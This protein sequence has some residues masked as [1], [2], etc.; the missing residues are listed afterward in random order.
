MI[1]AAD[2]VTID[3]IFFAAGAI[4]GLIGLGLPVVCMGLLTLIMTPAE[5]A[6]VVVV[7]AFIT[8]IQQA[9]VGPHLRAVFM[10]LWPMLLG[11]VVGTFAAGGLILVVDP[12]LALG[13]M[14]T[15]LL[16]YVMFAWSNVVL[17]VPR[18]LEPWAAPVVGFCTGGVAGTTGVLSIPSVPY[19]QALGLDK[20]ALVQALGLSFLVSTVAL[21]FSLASDITVDGAFLGQSAETI[22]VAVVGTW[23]GQHLRQFVSAHHFRTLFLAGLAGIGFSLCY[24]AAAD[25]PGHAFAS[26]LDGL[27]MIGH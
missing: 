13:L 18:P 11:I 1:F 19:M 12:R 4:K 27:M 24:R 17:A 8:N 25:L 6:K 26:V 23:A 21:G 9:F 16:A 20:N 14:G 5:A 7:P 15:A 3:G 2:R 22:A 10:R